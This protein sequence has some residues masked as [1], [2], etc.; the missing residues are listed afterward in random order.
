MLQAVS[1][2][3][4]PPPLFWKLPFYSQFLR[5]WLFIDST[6]KW[7]HFIFIFLCFLCLVY[8]TYYMSTRFIYVVANGS[9]PS[10]LKLNIYVCVYIY[11]HTHKHTHIY[12]CTHTHI[13]ITVSLFIHSLMDTHR[14]YPYL[15]YYE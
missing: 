2:K 8:F 6:N 14:L 12:I 10:F 1:P 15:D 4:P 11:V 13:H 5:I 9:I 3:F 7:D